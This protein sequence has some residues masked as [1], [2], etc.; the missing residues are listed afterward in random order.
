MDYSGLKQEVLLSLKQGDKVRTLTLRTL[1]S[2]VR[3]YAIA[4]YKADWEGKVSPDDI[5]E[6]VKKQIK[7][8]RESIEMFAAGGR[9]D[10]VEN[11][12]A[13][14]SVIERF[15]PPQIGE[16]DLRKIIAES[17]AGGE[18]NFGR[19]MGQIMAKCQGK[20]DGSRVS[21][22]LKEMMK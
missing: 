10:L 8:H 16:P 7:T 2:D 21:V 19:L 14:L 17:L 13:E 4:K 9:T 18:T 5:A 15:L 11:E 6:V 20:A 1:L 22:L 12:K 3:Y